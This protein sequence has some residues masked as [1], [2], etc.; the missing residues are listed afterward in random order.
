MH[1]DNSSSIIIIPKLKKKKKKKPFK[2]TC[3][4]FLLII[5]TWNGKLLEK[6]RGLLFHFTVTRPVLLHC[7]RPSKALVLN[8]KWTSELPGRLSIKQLS[9][10]LF[11]FEGKGR[12]DLSEKLE[13][14]V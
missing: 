2:T 12:K 14:Q 6:G 7:P 5:N 9:A 10:E 4:H 3:E 1:T 8:Q 13:W 11:P